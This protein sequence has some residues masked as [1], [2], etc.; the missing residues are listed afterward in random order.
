MQIEKGKLI[1]VRIRTFPNTK[2]N[3]FGVK[4]QLINED[5]DLTPVKFSEMA[6]DR[7]NSEFKPYFTVDIINDFKSYI[8]PEDTWKFGPWK[9]YLKRDITW[10]HFGNITGA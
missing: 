3:I 7:I 9:E 10:K 6:Y 4:L 1:N 5:R 2:E 8:K